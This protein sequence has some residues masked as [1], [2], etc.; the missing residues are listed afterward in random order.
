VNVLTPSRMAVALS[1]TCDHRS[2]IGAGHEF[3]AQFAAC[4]E[5]TAHYHRVGTASRVEALMGVVPETLG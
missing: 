5:N 3:L 4:L 1:R 2:Q